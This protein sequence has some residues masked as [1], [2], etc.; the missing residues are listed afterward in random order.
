[1]VRWPAVR[2]QR[3]RLRAR[4]LLGYSLNR[5]ARRIWKPRIADVL[6]S[7]DNAFIPRVRDAGRVVDGSI[8]MHNGLLIRPHGYYG[9]PMRLLL[10]R[11]RGVHEPQEERVFAEVLKAMP[12]RA[13]ILELGAYWGFYSMW[14]AREV[15][16]PTCILVEPNP[17]NLRVGQDHFA[18]NGLEGTFV[19]G[20][21]GAAA[22]APAVSVDELVGE[23]GI[24]RINVL[25][26]DIQGAE[27]AMLEGARQ[28]LAERKVDYIFLSLH[29]EAEFAD[30]RSVLLSHGFTLIAEAGMQDTYS[31]DGLLVG[32][33]RE[34]AGVE[35]MQISS[36]ARG[37]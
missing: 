23:H 2:A 10:E 33:R 17:R 35:P 8:V 36:K 13:L 20:G 6:A 30:C 37:A 7:P 1:L 15:E 5:R 24:E 29:G 22:G 21:I 12:R 18:L 3:L 28:T 26:A 25:H 31:Y 11:N 9:E 16:E 14:F 19:E 4:R 34:L 27:I 32:R